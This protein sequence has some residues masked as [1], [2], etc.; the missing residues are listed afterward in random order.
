MNQ[1]ALSVRK[2][3]EESL[4]GRAISK[5]ILEDINELTLKKIEGLDEQNRNQK[6]E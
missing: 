4:E 5:K 3:I 6:N 1:I 2:V